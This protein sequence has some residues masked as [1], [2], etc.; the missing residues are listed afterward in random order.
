MIL[1][2]S[3]TRIES[4][5]FARSGLKEIYIPES[6]TS[7]GGD[8]F[9]YCEQLTRV[10]IGSKVKTMDQGVFY[11]S[12]VKEA[13]VKALTPP[14]IALYLFSSK[15]VIHVYAKSL[16]AYKA[17][18]WAE[19]GTIVGDLDNYEDITPVELPR[20]DQQMVNGE[21]SDGKCYDMMGREVNTLLP[22]NIYIRNGKKIYQR[23]R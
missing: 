20:Y 7:I 5:A 12:A 4:N 11:S 9:A 15:P 8:A 17:S 23:R 16:A 10:V 18:P 1:P 13:Y 3:I 21:W 2:K 14:S 19:F 22:G 6:V